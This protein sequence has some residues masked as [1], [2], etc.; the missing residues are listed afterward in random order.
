MQY[1]G[2]VFR[3]A[4]AT[5]RTERD[6]TADLRGALPPTKERHHATQT[7]PKA[8]A[9]L[10]RAIEGYEGAFVTKCVLRLS[11]ML[12]VRQGELRQAK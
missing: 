4:V 10:L 9:A 7:T 8:V 1:A 2:K 6:I 11:P 3:Y 12:F 5:S